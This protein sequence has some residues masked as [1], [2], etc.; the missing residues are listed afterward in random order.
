MTEIPHT[1]HMHDAEAMD[2]STR[3]DRLLDAIELVQLDHREEARTLLRGLIHDYNDFEHAWLWM[4]VAVDSLDQS[5]LCLDNVLR[6]NPHNRQ[7]ASA[8]FRLRETEI[9]VERRRARLRIWRDTALGVF[10]L[11]FVGLCFAVML[12]YVA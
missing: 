3:I 9:R 5:T 6:V 1:E 4:S 8:L 12:T 11:L 2:D 10:W 7:A